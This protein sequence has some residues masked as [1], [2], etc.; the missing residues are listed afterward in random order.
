M[1]KKLIIGIDP[2]RKTGIAVYTPETKSLI[3]GTYKLHQAFDQVKKLNQHFNI[4]VVIENPNLWTHFQNVKNARAKMQGAGSVKRDYS[5]WT[6]FLDD[7]KITY[8]A[9]RPDKT[10]NGYAYDVELFKKI[11]GYTERCSE[12]ARVAALLVYK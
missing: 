11:T 8:K 6:D 3:L 12:H 7:Y 4:E 9:V 1:S 5:A 2:G 10:R